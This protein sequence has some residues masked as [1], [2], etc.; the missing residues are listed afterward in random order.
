MSER[1]SYSFHM[2]NMFH[3]LKFSKDNRKEIPP[4]GLSSEVTWSACAGLGRNRALS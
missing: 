1:N 4:L 2:L 3:M